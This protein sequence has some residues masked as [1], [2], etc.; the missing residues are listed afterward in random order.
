VKESGNTR[1]GVAYAIKEMTEEKILI[2]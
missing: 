2:L 1:E